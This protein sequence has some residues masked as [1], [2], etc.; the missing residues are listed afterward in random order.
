MAHGHPS[1][2]RRPRGP[3]RALGG[4]RSG[5]RARP[6][7]SR[8][9]ATRGRDGRSSEA[10]SRWMGVA[11][12]VAGAEVVGEGVAADAVAEDIEAKAAVVVAAIAREAA[13]AGGNEET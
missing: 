7:V 12:K 3:S 4:G 9:S 13:V 5:G 11:E 8:P 10:E 2:R 6:R 1:I